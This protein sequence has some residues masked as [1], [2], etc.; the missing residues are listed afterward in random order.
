[1]FG[2]PDLIMLPRTKTQKSPEWGGGGGGVIL[3]VR[4]KNIGPSGDPTPPEWLFG[5]ALVILSNS[6]AET[7]P[8]IV[9]Y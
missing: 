5:A 7:V 6:S 2:P 1:M 8:W 9:K 4:M 3:A